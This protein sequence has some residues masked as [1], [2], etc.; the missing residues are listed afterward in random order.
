MRGDSIA[1]K[2]TNE[3]SVVMVINATIFNSSDKPGKWRMTNI[4]AGMW[5]R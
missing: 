5:S 1:W 3:S 2:E 4:S